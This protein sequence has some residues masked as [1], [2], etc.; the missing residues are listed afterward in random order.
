MPKIPVDFP[1]KMV[2]FRARHDMGQRRLAE[3]CKVTTQTISYIENRRRST[4]TKLTLAKIEEVICNDE[5]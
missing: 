1:D 5:S 3:L 2:Q 4:A